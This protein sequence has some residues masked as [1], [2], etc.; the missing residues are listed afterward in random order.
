MKKLLIISVLTIV[1]FGAVTIYT[2]KIE[3]PF[4]GNDTYGFPL[5]YFIRFSGECAPYHTQLRL[6]IG[7]YWLMYC[8][9]Q[10]LL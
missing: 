4:D 1:V 3:T 8:F 9:Q 5:T 2:A 6:I 7:S 10:L